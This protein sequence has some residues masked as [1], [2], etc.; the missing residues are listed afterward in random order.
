[1]VY[2]LSLP[3]TSCR[4]VSWCSASGLH[5]ARYSAVKP[6]EK[7]L[8]RSL[9]SATTCIPFSNVATGCKLLHCQL[10]F[11][12]VLLFEIADWHT[13]LAAGEPQA[14]GYRLLKNPKR[15]FQPANP[16]CAADTTYQ[17]PSLAA[18]HTCT[19]FMQCY[20]VLARAC[21]WLVEAARWATTGVPP[22]RRPAECPALTAFK[23]RAAGVQPGTYCWPT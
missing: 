3:S 9:K 19:Q 17:S 2:Y 20:C 21:R 1:M 14:T 18:V 11:S 22:E 8:V 13:L 15:D 4:K 7:S 10:S 23:V 16:L 12:G 5:G 6:R